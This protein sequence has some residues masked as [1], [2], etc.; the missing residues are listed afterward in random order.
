SGVLVLN[1]AFSPR[2]WLPFVVAAVMAALDG[3]HCRDRIAGDLRPRRRDIRL[4]AR[5]A[6]ADARGAAASGRRA[7]EPARDRGGC[8]Y[9]RGLF[10]ALA[11]ELGGGATL[12]C[13]LSAG[14]RTFPT[15]CAAA[16]PATS[17]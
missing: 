3:L 2:V 13:L 14:I 4:L 16:S 11:A 7:P 15:G 8:R 1:A 12:L 6:P 10:P 5:R 9:A 17:R